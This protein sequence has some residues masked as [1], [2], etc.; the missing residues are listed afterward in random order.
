MSKKAKKDITHV[1]HTV[2]CCHGPDCTKNGAQATFKALRSAVRDAGLKHDVHFIKTDCT[3]PCKQGPMVIVCGAQ[4]VVWYR[5]ARPRDALP[6]VKGHL[7]GGRVLE[8]KRFWHRPAV[9]EISGDDECA[10]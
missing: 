9:D 6:L 7:A 1:R 4:G 8:D 2:F 3:G 5:K 10:D